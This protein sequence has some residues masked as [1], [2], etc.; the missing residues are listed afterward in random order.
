MRN[1]I[2]AL[3]QV[4]NTVGPVVWPTHPRTKKRLQ[5]TGLPLSSVTVIG[6]APYLRM[7]LLESAREADPDRFRGVQKEA[8][9]C[10]V[11][12][13]ALRN[14]TEWVETLQNSCNVLTSA[15]SAALVAV[16]NADARGPWTAQ[17][18]SGNAADAVLRASEAETR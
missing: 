11:P 1:I 8:F 12:C 15:D 14:E 13:I 10:Q 9:L 16:A 5:I 18:G 6:P 17:H 4:A 7:L 2:E 3:D